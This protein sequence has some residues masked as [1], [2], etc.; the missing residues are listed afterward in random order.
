VAYLA[1]FEPVSCRLAIQLCVGYFSDGR[2]RHR[3]FS[4]KNIRRDV[5]ADAIAAVVRAIAPLLTYPITKVRLIKKDRLVLEKPA[6]PGTPNTLNMLNTP[7]NSDSE[8][9]SPPSCHSGKDTFEVAQVVASRDRK[10]DI[11]Q[12]RWKGRLSFWTFGVSA[13]GVGYERKNKYKRTSAQMARRCVE[14]EPLLTAR[15]TLSDISC[16]TSPPTWTRQGKLPA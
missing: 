10:L 11:I 13:N 14:C 16:R 9:L 5:G 3:T 1:Y 8:S 6:S 12:K 7:N 15:G 4:I 2:E